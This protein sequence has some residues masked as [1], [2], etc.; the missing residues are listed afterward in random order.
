MV[1]KRVFIILA[2]EYIDS[3]RAVISSQQLFL[4]SVTSQQNPISVQPN[5][6]RP[7]ITNHNGVSAIS[8]GFIALVT[9]THHCLC[10][11]MLDTG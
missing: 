11:N 7:F 2:S 1:V 10:Y 3:L 5:V 4:R 6:W 8:G 9:P